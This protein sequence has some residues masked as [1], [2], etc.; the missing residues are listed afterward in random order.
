M[1]TTFG[2]CRDMTDAEK[3]YPWLDPGWHYASEKI[4][5]KWSGRARRRKLIAL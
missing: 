4:M 2:R 1:M 3:D 5:H